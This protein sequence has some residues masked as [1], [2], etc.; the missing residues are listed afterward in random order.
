[1]SLCLNKL[2]VPAQGCLLRKGARVFGLLG[3]AT[4]SGVAS[5]TTRDIPGS[6]A[7]TAEYGCLRLERLSGD[8][9]VS[10]TQIFL[11]V[12]SAYDY[13]LTGADASPDLARTIFGLLP[14]E[15]EQLVC[16]LRRGSFP[17]LGF[18][19]NDLRCSISSSIIPGYWPHVVTSNMV[20]HGNVVSLE[21]FMRILV[22]SM[23]Q[24]RL[25]S[26]YPGLQPLFRRIMQSM[27]MHRRGIPFTRETLALA[28]TPS[29]LR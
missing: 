14:A 20:L 8:E 25:G 18:S 3:K 5:F 16:V 27:A 21:S 9:E 22:N 17:I 11:P 10:R 4:A 19:L 13:G 29:W 12:P 28:P 26:R 6:W 23:S 7:L 15:L 24:S 2:T 1:M